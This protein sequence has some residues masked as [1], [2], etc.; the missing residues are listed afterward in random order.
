MKTKMLLT[1]L[2]LMSSL[3][4]DGADDKAKADKATHAKFYGIYVNGDKGYMLEDVE[5][6][7]RTQK[8][9]PGAKL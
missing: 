8:I 9:G 2:I 5:A 3:L 4:S 7:R 1:A 6:V